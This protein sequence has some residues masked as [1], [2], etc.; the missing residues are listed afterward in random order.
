LDSLLQNLESEN[1]KGPDNLGDLNYVWT[2][3]KIEFKETGCEIID[4]IHTA[5]ALS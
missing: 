4:W 3:I 2:N 1:V 5:Q